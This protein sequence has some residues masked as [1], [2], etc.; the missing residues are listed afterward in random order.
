MMNVCGKF[1]VMQNTCQ[2]MDRHRT[3]SQMDDQKTQCRWWPTVG[4]GGKQILL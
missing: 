1:H 3:D 2:Q 4:G